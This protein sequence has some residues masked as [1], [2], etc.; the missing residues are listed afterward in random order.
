MFHVCHRNV[1]NKNK[2]KTKKGHKENNKNN[3]VLAWVNEG[4]MEEGSLK[5]RKGGGGEGGATRREKGEVGVVVKRRRKWQR[6][7]SLGE[8]RI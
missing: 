8:W 1:E 5:E 6:E 3:Y 7:R 4:K 2:N